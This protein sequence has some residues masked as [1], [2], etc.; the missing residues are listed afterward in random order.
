MDTRAQSKHGT[1]ITQSEEVIA[2]SFFC[3][4][5]VKLRPRAP[6]F[7]EMNFCQLDPLDSVWVSLVVEMTKMISLEDDVVTDF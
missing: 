2:D 4:S 1:K 7:L 3:Y 5:P 6:P